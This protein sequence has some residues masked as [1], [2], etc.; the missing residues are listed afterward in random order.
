MILNHALCTFLQIFN[1]HGNYY[2]IVHIPKTQLLFQVRKNCVAISFIDKKRHF[3]ELN[4][5]LSLAKCLGHG[6]CEYIRVINTHPSAWHAYTLQHTRV[7][8]MPTRYNTPECVACLH[9]TTH[10]SVWHAYTLQQNIESNTAINVF[11]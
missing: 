4:P 10:P 9:A 8:G 1:A 5:A 2:I 11:H 6:L 3:Y 7:C